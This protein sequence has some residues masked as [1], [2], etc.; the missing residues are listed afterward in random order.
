MTHDELLAKINDIEQKTNHTPLAL[1]VQTALLTQNKA[2]RAVVELA[3]KP[4]DASNI[5]AAQ[6]AWFYEG[7]NLA[8]DNVVDA[9]EK[10][11]G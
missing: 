8:L 5:P 4:V 3:M 2:L 11:L 7:Y 1:G 10:E 6:V 9:I